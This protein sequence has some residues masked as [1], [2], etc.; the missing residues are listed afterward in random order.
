MLILVADRGFKQKYFQTSVLVVL[1]CGFW[2]I[3]D[4]LPTQSIYESPHIQ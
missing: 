1:T 2:E 3:L 4:P